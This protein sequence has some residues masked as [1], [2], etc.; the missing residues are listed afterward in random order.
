MSAFEGDTADAAAEVHQ[1]RTAVLDAAE[2]FDTMEHAQARQQETARR[3][4][5][6]A[7][8]QATE[9]QAAVEIERLNL[10]LN[11]QH[12][13]NFRGENDR[14]IRQLEDRLQ[15]VTEGADAARAAAEADA[16]TESQALAAG[17]GGKGAEVGRRG[18]G[19]ASRDT[20]AADAARLVADAD[21]QREEQAAARLARLTEDME[22]EADVRR[23]MREQE[24]AES[25]AA[26]DQAIEIE[27]QRVEGVQAALDEEAAAREKTQA[28]ISDIQGAT[29]AGMGVVTA[30]VDASLEGSKKSEE[31]QA[32]IKAKAALVTSIIGAALETAQ[33]VASFA[34]LNIP[35]GIAHAGAAVMYGISAAK[36]AAVAGGSAG[37]APSAP[38][39][40]APGGGPSAAGP[41]GG[42]GGD[43]ININWGSSALVY[44]ADR[45]ALGR[46]IDDMVTSARARR[47]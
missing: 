34:S 17:H 19:G 29:M 25:N 1:L 5:Q 27:Q 35:Q 41:A 11:T 45:D 6:L 10:A 3:G 15:M 42:K 44:A 39:A 28:L 31:E 36:A 24:I 21:A 18:G 23:L 32:K 30:A 20:S 38:S 26:K 40:S 14:Q 46:D 43:V 47:A 4:A 13:T 2:A 16:R 7:L 9:A 22:A 12:L 37:S 33:S 8:G